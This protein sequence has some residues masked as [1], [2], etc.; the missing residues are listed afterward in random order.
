MEAARKAD[1]GGKVKEEKRVESD[2]G[3]GDCKEERVPKVGNGRRDHENDNIKP[4]CT[5]PNQKEL[6]SC[7]KQMTVMDGMERSSEELNSKASSSTQK[8]KDEQLESAKAE[9]GEVKEENQ[10]LRMY[11]NQI[12][13]DYQNLQMQFH[14]IVQQETKKST[15]PPNNHQEAEETELVSLTLGRTSTDPKKVENYVIPSKGQVHEQDKEG[16]AL[17]LD[18]QVHEQD[19]EGLALGLDCQYEMPK[20]TLA[21]SSLNASPENSLE[22]VKEEARD[23]LP[24]PKILKTM[25]SGEDGVS[26]QSPA[27]KTRVSVRVRCDTP[28]MNDGCQWRKYGQKIAKGNPCPRAYYRCTVALNCPVRKQAGK[29]DE[30]TN[31]AKND[32]MNWNPLIKTGNGERKSPRC[33]SA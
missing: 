1:Y 26:E 21:E 9:M 16:L 30:N 5:K 19:K 33:P 24:P 20:I 3:E 17:G 12:M 18:C 31:A 29:W 23:T 27:K 4:S 25:R 11:L 14:D 6:T 7:D 32:Q 28:T 22:E 2:A 15:S 10:R 8:E 13:K